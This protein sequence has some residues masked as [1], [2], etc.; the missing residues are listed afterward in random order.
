MST[1]GRANYGETNALHPFREGN[2]RAQRAFW[3][4]LAGEADYPI[5]WEHMERRENLEASIAIMRGD[6]T[7]LRKMLDSLID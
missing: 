7:P 4:Q 1:Y 5:H 3:A 2:G 6:P